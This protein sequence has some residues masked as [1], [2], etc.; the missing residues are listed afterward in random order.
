MSTTEKTGQAKGVSVRGVNVSYGVVHVIRDLDLE[1]APGEFIVL[2]G[3]SGCGK[4]TLLSVIAG[5]RDVSGGQIWIGNENVTWHEPKDRDI[6]MVF[7]S[8]ALYPQMSVR[9]NL[10]FGL[11]MTGG[12]KALIEKRV[13]EAADILQLNGLLERKPRQL[14]GGQRQ[15]V[16]IGRALVRQAGVFLFDEPL[17]NLD[18]KLRTELRGELK[19]LHKQLGTTMIFVTHDQIE[20]LTL[21]DRIAVMEG[22][23]IRQIGTPKEIYRHPQNRFVAGFIG[24][25]GMN[26]FDGEVQVDGGIAR[27]VGRGFD[28]PLAGYEAASGASLVPTKAVLGLR[29]EHVGTRLTGTAAFTAS[30][31]VT[32]AEPMGAETLLWARLGEEPLSIRVDTLQGFDEASSITFEIDPTLVSLFDAKSGQRL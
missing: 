16:A 18:A 22:G 31:P 6:G 12:D 13:A 9:G 11:R 30:S 27:F 28:L 19:R 10:S 8:Y 5:L 14:S 26:F 4:S 25:P 20:A 29:P 7:Q 3:A 23:V 17:S 24:S 32:S 21:A 2:L 1:I 15:R